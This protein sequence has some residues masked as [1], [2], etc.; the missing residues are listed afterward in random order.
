[1]ML[2]TFPGNL[3]TLIQI[4]IP[5]FGFD[6]LESFLDWEVIPLLNIDWDSLEEFTE[7]NMY[8]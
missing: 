8:G 2:I 6:V 5:V 7:S 4:I 1:M 3:A